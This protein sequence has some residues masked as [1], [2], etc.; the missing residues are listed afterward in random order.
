MIFM[1]RLS[2]RGQPWIY[3]N[4]CLN[5]KVLVCIFLLGIFSPNNKF[6]FINFAVQ[7]QN[8]ERYKKRMPAPE[9]T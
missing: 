3:D 8:D 4:H 7:G 2:W 5:K 6:L 1:G 9:S